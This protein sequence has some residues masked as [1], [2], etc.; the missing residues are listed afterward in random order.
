MELKEGMYVR[1]KNKGIFK[2]TNEK[3]IEEDGRYYIGVNGTYADVYRSNIIKSSYDIIDL[4]E[5]GDYVNG[6]FV[7][8]M[9]DK[10]LIVDSKDSWCWGEGVMPI[11]EIKSIVTKE[12]FGAIK[13]EIK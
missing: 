11:E 5:V 2:V 13:Y 9:Q 3:S 6:Y 1:H 8:E 12:Q 4:I 7:E 10:F